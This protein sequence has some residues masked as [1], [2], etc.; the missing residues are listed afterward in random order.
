VAIFFARIAREAPGFGAVSSVFWLSHA[1][2]PSAVQV[3]C[4]QKKKEEDTVL[5][6]C[7]VRV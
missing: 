6:L 3:P 1:L 7:D 5:F 4:H 2:L